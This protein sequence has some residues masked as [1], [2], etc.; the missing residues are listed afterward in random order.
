VRLQ[1]IDARQSHNSATV[2]D[3]CANN[4]SAD[5]FHAG[6]ARNPDATPTWNGALRPAY[7]SLNCRASEIISRTVSSPERWPA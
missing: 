6:K 7:R 5:C 3:T 2:N 4:M 1:S